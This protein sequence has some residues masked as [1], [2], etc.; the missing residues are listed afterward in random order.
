VFLAAGPARAKV[1]VE[2]PA[3]MRKGLEVVHLQALVVFG[4]SVSA[5]RSAQLLQ[6]VIEAVTPIGTSTPARRASPITATM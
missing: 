2:T 4:Y 1:L 6:M 3:R 5:S